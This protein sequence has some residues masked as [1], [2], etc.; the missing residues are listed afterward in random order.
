[1]RRLLFLKA[2]LGVSVNAVTETDQLFAGGSKTF[3]CARFCVRDFWAAYHGEARVYSL[4]S[5]TSGSTRMARHAGI[6]EAAKPVAA[7]VSATAARVSG[8]V[9]LISNS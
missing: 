3:L 5:A 7:S 1:M 2:K 8:S 4:R 6:I 9:A